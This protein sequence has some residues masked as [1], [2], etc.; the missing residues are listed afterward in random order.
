[1]TQIANEMP[2]NNVANEMPLQELDREQDV[3]NK[4]D[5]VKELLKANGWDA[6]L[7]QK[8]CN[9]SW[10][11]SGGDSSG[12]GMGQPLAA[13]FITPD[14]RL[15]IAN[16]CNSPQI[17]E[18]EIPQLG[19]SLKE[20]PW[21]EPPHVLLD[22][23]CRGRKVA[24]DTGDRETIDASAEIRNLRLQLTSL[25]RARMRIV[26]RHVTHAVE[27]TARTLE[28]GQT[29]AEIAGQLSHRLVHRQVTP[30]QMQVMVDGRGERHR[31]WSYSG[32]PL[33]KSCVLSAVGSRWGVCVAATR[34]VCF[35]QPSNSLTEA[36]QAAA[37]VEAT[38]IFFSRPETLASKLFGRISRI[39]EKF[40]YE[41]E[42][43]LCDQGEIIGY[44]ACEL[45]ISST[46]HIPLTA[47]MALHL[48]PTIGPAKLGDTILI[49]EN[50]YE[51]LRPM[52]G[53]PQ[54]GVSVKGVSI[55]CPDMLVREH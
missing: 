9:F 45:S 47:N 40:G 43:R 23:L 5:L 44:Q 39:Y 11:T 41:R 32:D 13:L 29:E 7:L 33:R 20:R 54:L 26:G 8:P 52:E 34:T 1:M 3:R 50:G 4:H 14:S 27:A 30:L 19:F 55:E 6:L 37:M 15:V 49:A 10:L 46:N 38:G 35:G 22:D 17:F 18:E 28:L 2:P 48:H 53:W 24:S 25:E 31:H 12:R 51:P 21:T 42:W 16:N 36:Y